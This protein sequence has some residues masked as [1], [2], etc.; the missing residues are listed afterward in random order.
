[1][2]SD[3]DSWA[4]EDLGRMMRTSMKIVRREH[5]AA[6][7]R[8]S[9]VRARRSSPTVLFPDSS[10]GLNSEGD[11]SITKHPPGVAGRII[12]PFPW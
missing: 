4:R 7:K 9:G 6:M 8:R 2:M 1:M 5:R 10:S 3:L 11:G 12:N